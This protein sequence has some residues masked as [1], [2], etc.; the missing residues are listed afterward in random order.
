M[1]S[2]QLKPELFEELFITAYQLNYER[3][4]P[5]GDHNYVD[6]SDDEDDDEM[7][8][9]DIKKTY[10][11]TYIDSLIT[12]AMS[13]KDAMSLFMNIVQTQLTF[14]FRKDETYLHDYN[15]ISLDTEAAGLIETFHRFVEMVSIYKLPGSGLPRQVNAFMSTMNK[16]TNLRHMDIS[17]VSCLPD[18]ALRKLSPIFANLTSFYV[19]ADTMRKL[20]RLKISFPK[21]ERMKMTGF[22]EDIKKVVTTATH[23]PLLTDLEVKPLPATYLYE[24]GRSNRMKELTFAR[25]PFP[26]VKNVHIYFEQFIIDKDDFIEPSDIRRIQDWL[27]K[28][29]VVAKA[30]VSI[31]RFYNPYPHKGPE[32]Y[33]QLH[34]LVKTTDF[35]V[36]L[37]VNFLID[38][39]L[40]WPDPREDDDDNFYEQFFT[41]FENVYDDGFRVEYVYHE[42]VPGKTIEHIVNLE[43]ES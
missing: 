3:D 41:G 30:E 40:E 36:P 19:D 17:E 38:G 34:N 24:I 7:I 4:R 27:K 9:L 16:F 23:F 25:N 8:H 39:R 11:I 22:L 14:R 43:F 10:P 26:T 31:K 12:F 1:S 15:D 35:G 21:L 33:T 18:V 2:V 28:F 37:K 42:E 13:G 32:W 5:N 29:P 20:K 6:S